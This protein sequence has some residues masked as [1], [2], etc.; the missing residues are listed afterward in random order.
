[1][2]E[3]KGKLRPLL[4]KLLFNV[5]EVLKEHDGEMKGSEL[6]ERVGEI[7]DQ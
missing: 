6:I 7:S 1:M 5:F 2:I 4:E 3:S